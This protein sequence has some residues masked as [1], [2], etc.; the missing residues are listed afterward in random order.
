MFNVALDKRHE[1]R[2]LTVDELDRLILAAETGPVILGMIGAD[3]AMLYRVAVGS[4]F[5]AN[6]LRSLTPE[7][8]DLCANP[9]T[10]TV[11]A[12]YSKHDSGMF[13]P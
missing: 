3:R 4:G 7:S 10:I 11:E 1:R 12:G 9:P 5:R 2:A 8:F 13:N 6:E